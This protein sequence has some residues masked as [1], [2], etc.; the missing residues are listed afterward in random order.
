MKSWYEQ[1]KKAEWGN[2]N[3]LKQTF[4]NASIIGGKRVAF[5]IKG[6]N[7]RLIVDIE[8]FIEQIFIVLI[9]SHKEYDKINAKTIE[10]VKSDKN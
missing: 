2:H 10:Y 8:Y 6:N 4:G 5:N 7:Y 3:D 9:G 1:A